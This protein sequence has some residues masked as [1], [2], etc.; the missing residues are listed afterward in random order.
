MVK[1]WQY[2]TEWENYPI[3]SGQVWETGEHR[4]RAGDLM[5]D[6]ALAW[7]LA[8]NAD[9]MYVDPPWNQ[10]NIS[11]FFTKA[12]RQGLAPDFWQFLGRVVEVASRVKCDSWIEMGNQNIDRLKSLVQS[13]GGSVIADWKVVYYRT[14]PSRLIQV[15]WGNPAVEGL[16]LHGIDD[17]ETPFKVC[18][19]LPAASKVLDV[20]AGKGLTA[21]GALKYGH[22]FVGLE[23]NPRRLA[24]AIGKTERGLANA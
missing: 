20:C 9:F 4:V 16:D 18:E 5:D 3:E 10:G 14:Q 6:A 11:S 12:G 24:H 22:T 15:S 1:S 8:Q 7:V 17:E 19:A 23:L 13:R 2:G 21:E